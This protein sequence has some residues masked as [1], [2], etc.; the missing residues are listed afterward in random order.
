M[1]YD[2]TTLL[3]YRA[4]FSMGIIVVVFKDLFRMLKIKFQKF[5]KPWVR[6]SGILEMRKLFREMFVQDHSRKLCTSKI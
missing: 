1:M 4:K 3:L 2:S 6:L 5:Y